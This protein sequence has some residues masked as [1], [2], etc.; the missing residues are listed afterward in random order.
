MSAG[1]AGTDAPEP[2]QQRAR[3]HLRVEG[4]V[5]GVGFRRAVQRHAIRGG[6]GGWVQNLADGAVEIAASGERAA[7]VAF[8]RAVEQ[9]SAPARVSRVVELPPADEDGLLPFAIRGSAAG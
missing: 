7:L 1:S 9:E 4:R 3:C 5:Q 6:I 2:Q 8:R